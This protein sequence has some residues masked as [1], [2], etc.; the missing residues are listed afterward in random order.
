[1]RLFPALGRY[2][3]PGRRCT[4]RPFAAKAVATGVRCLCGSGLDRGSPVLEIA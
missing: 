3:Q 2:L 1:M 4:V